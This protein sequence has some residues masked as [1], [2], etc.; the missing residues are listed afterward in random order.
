M[1]CA[2]LSDYNDGSNDIIIQSSDKT[3]GNLYKLMDRLKDGQ[4]FTGQDSRINP[5]LGLEY[6]KCDQW[7]L[8]PSVKGPI[9]SELK[10]QRKDLCP[11]SN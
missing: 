7:E 8:K 2:P 5:E 11:I 6:I 10:Y 9:P 3:R 1:R 4:Y